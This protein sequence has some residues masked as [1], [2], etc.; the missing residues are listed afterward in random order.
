MA[1]DHSVAGGS[2]ANAILI[3]RQIRDGWH[4]ALRAFGGTVEVGC[5]LCTFDAG[6]DLVWLNYATP[7]PAA[8]GDAIRAAMP[9]LRDEFRQRLRFLR[10]EF[11]D[12]LHADFAT[13]VAEEG[14]GVQVRMP[15]MVCTRNE[16]R[17]LSGSGRAPR[18]GDTR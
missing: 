6:S 17:P 10:F 2:D 12:A 9:Q 15:A 14:L 18:V 7:K 3:L 5:F 4:D 8:D 16:L 1:G 11:F 13:F